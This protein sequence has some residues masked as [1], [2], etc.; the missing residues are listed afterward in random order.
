MEAFW[1]GF[2]KKAGKI[3]KGAIPSKKSGLAKALWAM[4]TGGLLAGT[5]ANLYRKHKEKKGK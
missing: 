1:D 3:A 2:E 5:G 4:G